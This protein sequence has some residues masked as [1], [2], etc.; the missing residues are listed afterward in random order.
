MAANAWANR[1]YCSVAT[2]GTGTVTVGAAAASNMLTPADAGAT[3]GGL[4]TYLLEEGNDF[5][6]GEGIYAA[7][8]TTLTR[9]II[10]VS[11]IAGVV[12]TTKMTLAGAARVRF[13]ESATDFSGNRKFPSTQV[14]SG[15]A[16]TL[17]DYAEFSFTITAAF[18]TAGNS[19]WAYTTQAGLGTKIGNT[20]DGFNYNFNGTPTI[21]TGSG[22]VSF[23]GFP[24]TPSFAGGF[25]VAGLNA[26]WTWPASRTYI[27]A[28]FSGTTLVLAGQGSAAAASLLAA[29]NMTTGAAHTF[30]ASGSVRAT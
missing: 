7:S 11:K 30:A 21:G 14:A 19:S 13:V 10:I 3:D 8:G 12:G 23:S 17:D 24:Y 5:E 28:Q 18:A 26:N 9:P 27:S 1:V 25:A 20:V 15:D 6:L 22:T 2:T 29:S 4:Y 16:N